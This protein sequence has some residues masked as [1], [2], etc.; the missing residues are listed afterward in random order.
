MIRPQVA[1]LSKVDLSHN[2]LEELPEELGTIGPS[3]RA[4]LLK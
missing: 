4:L 1:E 3:L 2:E